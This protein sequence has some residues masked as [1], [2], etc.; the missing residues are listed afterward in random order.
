MRLLK[1]LLVVGLLTSVA[2][3]AIGAAETPAG[4]PAPDTK[5]KVSKPTSLSGM[6]VQTAGKTLV[7][8]VKGKKGAPDTDVNVATDDNTKFLIDYED[9]TLA[10]LK[11]EMT[12]TITP[13]TGTAVDVKAHVKGVTGKVVKV[14]GRTLVITIKKQEVTVTTDDKTR[15]VIDGKAG[16]TLADIQAGMQVKVIPETGTA[17]KIA[18]IPVTVKVKPA[19]ADTGAAAVPQ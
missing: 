9:G 7:V 8:R 19:K 2:G 13:D 11:P 14:D 1:I 12:V 16:G 18:V 3:M 5:A 10:D 4:T 15:I 6:L 17:T